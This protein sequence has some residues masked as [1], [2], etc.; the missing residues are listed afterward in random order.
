MPAGQILIIRDKTL[1]VRQFCEEKNIPYWFYP[2]QEVFRR[3]KFADKQTGKPA[4][5]FLQHKK[6]QPKKFSNSRFPQK[7]SKKL[8]S[9][10]F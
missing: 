7:H 9:D 1:L 10:P 4:T 3:K 5:P 6:K 2:I 8:K